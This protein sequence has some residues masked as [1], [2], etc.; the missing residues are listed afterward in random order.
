M[1]L[2]QW[3]LATVLILDAALVMTARAVPTTS[4]VQSVGLSVG[5]DSVAALSG[6]GLA[7]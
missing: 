7:R 6:A 2:L 1:K 5:A 3:M 4:P